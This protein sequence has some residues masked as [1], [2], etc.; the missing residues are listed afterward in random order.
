MNRLVWLLFFLVPILAQGRLEAG[1]YLQGGV[2]PTLEAALALEEGEVLLRLQ[3]GRGALGYLG[4]LAL[5]PLG[6][7]AYGVQ[8]EVGEGGVGL[9]LFLEGG[10]GP[11]ALEGRLSY[12]PQGALPLF[13]EEGLYGRL[14]FRYRLGPRE[15]VGL[16]L[17]RGRA[18]ATYALREGAT[19]TLGVGAEG[20]PYLVLGLRGEVGEGGEVLDL[21]LRLGG[22]NRL[23]GG[24]YL[25]Q[26]SLLFILSHPPAGSLTLW[27][28]DLGLEAGFRQA[29]YAWVRYAWR[30]P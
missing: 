20:P 26:A 15:V 7:L 9:A 8:G 10:A 19:Y 29:P 14:F 13:P 2:H 16:L 4:S 1:A 28:G 22:L 6:F 30:W 12:R 27:L 25:G 24:L 11:L 3:P 21:A 23:E 18:E 17:E 5:G